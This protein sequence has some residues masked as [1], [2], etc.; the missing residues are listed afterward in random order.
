VERSHFLGGIVRLA[1]HDFMASEHLIY[2]FNISIMFICSSHY[3][4]MICENRTT[5]ASLQSP[6]DRMDALIPITM[7]MPVCPRVCGARA[8]C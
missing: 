7:P 8:V 1:A 5:T 4:L 3:A 2:T 6:T